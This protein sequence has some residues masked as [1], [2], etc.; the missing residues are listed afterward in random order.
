MQTDYQPQKKTYI[1]CPICKKQLQRQ[2]RYKQNLNKVDTETKRIKAFIPGIK[3]PIIVNDYRSEKP[4]K[5]MNV[6]Y[7]STC[8]IGFN[9]RDTIKY[10]IKTAVSAIK[11][12]CREFKQKLN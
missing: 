5:R 2:I 9:Y 4:D 1:L 8:K 10:T 11:L 3:G 7:C 6:W 12:T